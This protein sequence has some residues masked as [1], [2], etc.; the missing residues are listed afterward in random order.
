MLRNIGYFVLFVEGIVDAITTYVGLS[1]G[2]PEANILLKYIWHI[3]GKEVLTILLVWW[4]F[5]RIAY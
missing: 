4:A 5:Y 3:F 2:Y 1:L